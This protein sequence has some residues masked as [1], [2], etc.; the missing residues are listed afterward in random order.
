MNDGVSKGQGNSRYLKSNIPASTTL[1][2]LI[3]M[4]N[5]GTFPV[6]FNG[7]N[8]AGWL[9][10][11]TA[12]NKAN[13]FSD[14]T[15]AKYPTGTETVDGALG[16]IP[17]AV[18]AVGDLKTT[19]RSSLGSKWLLC[20]GDVVSQTEYP[21]LYSRLSQQRFSNGWSTPDTV[22]SNARGAW[23]QVGSYWIRYE[24]SEAGGD[25]IYYADSPTKLGTAITGLTGFMDM[26][27]NGTYY[28]ALCKGSN[29]YD[30]EIR[31]ATSISGPYTYRSIQN[32][33]GSRQ[34]NCLN[35]ICDSSNRFVFAYRYQ[36]NL[37]LVRG[38]NPATMSVVAENIQENSS[39]SYGDE[40]YYIASGNGYYVLSHGSNRSAE[41]ALY[42]QTETPSTWKETSLAGI[43]SF[44]N[45]QFVSQSCKAYGNLPSNLS[46]QDDTRSADGNTPIPCGF[47]GGYY[48][49][50]SREYN[51]VEHPSDSIE[52]ITYGNTLPLL[53]GYNRH[54]VSTYND[55]P[56]AWWNYEDGLYIW[57]PYNTLFANFP[58]RRL[59]A[60]SDLSGNGQGVYTYIKAK[61]G[62]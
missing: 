6:D 38:S 32:G 30:V 52:A 26:A 36:D 29:G 59:P 41:K 58:E 45:N 61:E 16:A 1:Q 35:I 8:E 40:S 28:V 7:I 15:A 47:L 10:I 27:Y 12:L 31:Y 37:R 5:N 39:S 54:A 56:D 17:D 24:G 22:A 4:L 9:Q 48:F 23:K 53:S 11:G 55:G 33:A 60:I 57:G 2:Q 3:S 19:V 51:T 20:N 62:L 13:L 46:G 43:F 42:A 44:V 21:E 25:T 14:Q 49:Y 50:I 18:A 34:A